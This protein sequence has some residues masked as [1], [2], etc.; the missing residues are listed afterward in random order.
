MKT[1]F[2]TTLAVHGLWREMTTWGFCMKDGWFSVSPYVCWSPC[3][4][5]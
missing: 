5:L 2:A 1:G 3:L 4:V